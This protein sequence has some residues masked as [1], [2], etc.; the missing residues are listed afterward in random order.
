MPWRS[1]TGF[2]Q[3]RQCKVRMGRDLWDLTASIG[4]AHCT[5]SLRVMD[6]MV[7]AEAAMRQAAERGG[8]AVISGQP[9]QETLAATQS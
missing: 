3:V 5:V 9:L 2:A 6:I 4:V 8:D 1:R 7:S